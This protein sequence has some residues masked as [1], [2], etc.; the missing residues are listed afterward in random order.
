MKPVNV[1]VPLLYSRQAA[2]DALGVSFFTIERDIKL[3]RI[4]VRK[5]GTRT[6]VPRSELERIAEEGM[7]CQ[8]RKTA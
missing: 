4:A 8:P 3:G 7:E 5:Y 2:A 6:L 1:N